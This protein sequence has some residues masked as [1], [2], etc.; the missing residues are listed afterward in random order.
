[1][2]FT[3]PKGAVREIRKEN[4]LLLKTSSGGHVGQAERKVLVE[5]M[6]HESA[7]WGHGP[8]YLI[9]RDGSSVAGKVKRSTAG[10]TPPEEGLENDPRKVLEGLLKT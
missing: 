2:L 8:G 3:I 4:E 1:L 10:S 9:K 5:H 6:E 7:S